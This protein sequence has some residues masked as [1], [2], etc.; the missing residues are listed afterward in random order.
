[1]DQQPTDNPD[2]PDAIRS[3]IDDTRQRMDDT[4]D[5]LSQ[6]LK[7]RHLLDEVL[8]FLRP[9]LAND[10]G[11][12]KEKISDRASS[13]LSGITTTVKAHPVPALVIGAG[14]AWWI[15]ESRKPSI[16]TTYV[17]DEDDLLSSYADET[18]SYETAYGRTTYGS[19]QEQ[20]GAETSPSYVSGDFA[21]SAGP[22]ETGYTAGQSDAGGSKFSQATSAMAGRASA[23]KQRLQETAAGLG[24]RARTGAADL[25]SRAADIRARAQ[26]RSRELYSRGRQQVATTA[27]QHPLQTGLGI[28]VLGVI[29]GLALPTHRRVGELVGP[30]AG[31]LKQ[32]AQETGRDLADR[33]RHVVEA[34]ATAVKNE[35]QAQGLTPDA[36]REKAGIIASKTKEAVTETA[37]NE[38]LVSNGA[39]TGSGSATNPAAAPTI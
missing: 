19:A 11:E 21:P 35:V 22:G 32:R 12:L 31:R 1:M 6:R 18:V 9:R 3:E 14:I 29:A 26:E 2:N 5:A 10:G 27:D 36:L 15:Y 13:L 34:A 20:P 30:T 7:G 17:E 39:Q 28:L 25:R 4:I 38:G 8:G 16:D 23:A 24:E 33:G 37:R